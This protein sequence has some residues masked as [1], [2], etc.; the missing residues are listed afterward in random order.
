[1]PTVMTR[2]AT[3]STPIRQLLSAAT[4]GSSLLLAA[5][6]QAD[7]LKFEV[8]AYRWQTD[9]E[10]HVQS[11]GDSIDLN[12]DL[13]FDDDDADT[14]YAVLEHPIPILPNL[15]LQYTQI[16]T[17]ASGQ[18]S[19][20]FEFDGTVF[21]AD[22]P[23]QSSLDLT[24]TD[25][26]LYYQLLDNAVHLDVG[27]TLR[28]I[29]GSVDIRSSGESATEDLEVVLPLLYAAGRVD[30]PL[31]FYVGADLNGLG[32]GGQGMFDYRVNAGW[33]SPVLLGVEVGMR[34]F[35]IDYDDDDDEADVTLDGVYGAVTFQF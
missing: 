25:A 16:D 3:V 29:D 12:D 23:V 35:D 9:Y 20:G 8:G 33:V 5:A 18:T 26:T 6:A 2:R 27:L 32:A 14:L 34:R 17:D 28:Y 15:R 30:L 1:M 31:G 11:G 4:L 7:D 13:G 21:P 19:E 10:G 24:H 22:V